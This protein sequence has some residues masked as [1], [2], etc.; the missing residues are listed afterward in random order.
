MRTG[1]PLFLMVLLVVLAAA[2]SGQALAASPTPQTPNETA[3]PQAT[4]QPAA[5]GF[6]T[7]EDAIREYLAGVANADV[8]RILQASAIDE[9][10]DGFRFAAA[11]DRLQALVL[12]S[13]LAP[14]EYPFYADINRA[15]S[16]DRILSQVTMLAYSLL[17]SEEID[18]SVIVPVDTA[19]AESFVREVDPSRLA[20]LTVEDIRF[21]NAQLEHK[22]TY[23]ANAATQASIYGADEL[24]ER[25]VLFSLDGNLYDIGFTLLRYGDG[26]KVLDQV[27]ALAGT[28]S[29][30][31]ARPT[32]A[33]EFDR[34]TSGD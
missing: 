14:A 30:G 34:L 7:P 1:R 26:W 18:G 15:R 19:R 2:G 5:A 31:T 27:A 9:M 33:D 4:G 12:T 3:F 23:L 16:S 24:T 21:S 20:G 8:S 11:A 32:T 29:L 10:S 28:S 25:S 6:L 17:S 13:S 22:A